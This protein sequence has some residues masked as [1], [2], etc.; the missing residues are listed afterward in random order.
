MFILKN[1]IIQKFVDIIFIQ[2]GRKQ[3]GHFYIFNHF[4][5]GRMRISNSNSHIT[6]SDIESCGRLS[7]TKDHYLNNFGSTRVPYVHIK[8]QGHR[9]ICSGE[10]R[11]MRIFTIYGQGGH[12]G[13][14]I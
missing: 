2:I 13:H 7:L 3:Y 11:F 12:V 1:T 14:V 4:Y 10:K 9:S 6:L 8:V 5:A